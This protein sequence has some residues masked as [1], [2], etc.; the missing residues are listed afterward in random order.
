MKIVRDESQPGPP[1]NGPAPPLPP[2]IQPAQFKEH[3]LAVRRPKAKFHS[4]V[5]K[6]GAKW[7][8]MNTQQRKISVSG[9]GGRS[10]RE[11]SAGNRLDVYAYRC[12]AVAARNRKNKLRP[13][14]PLCPVVTRRLNRNSTG[15]SRFRTILRI[16]S[17]L[18]QRLAGPTLARSVDL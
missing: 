13:S 1:A 10:A 8:R 16:T 15:P 17:R 7:Y 4:V 9:F 2:E 14:S 5:P 12:V 11:C 6:V 3:A 18:C